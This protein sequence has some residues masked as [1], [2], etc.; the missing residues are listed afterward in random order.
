MSVCDKIFEKITFNSLFKYLNDQSGFRPDY[1]CVHQ[2]LLITREIYK[3][4]DANASLEVKGVFLTLSKAFDKVWHDGL[5]YKL[6]RLGVY[7]KYNELIHLFLNYRQQR[8]I[9]N[10]QCSI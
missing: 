1:S 6:K 5:M 10:S 9:L 8:V 7:G 4:F 3:A 2:L